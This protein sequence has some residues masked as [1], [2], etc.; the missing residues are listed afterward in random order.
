LD[1]VTKGDDG[2]QN[3]QLRGMIRPITDYLVVNEIYSLE[4]FHIL[5][6]AVGKAIRSLEGVILKDINEWTFWE[7]A[8]SFEGQPSVVIISKSWQFINRWV[9][10]S[11][12]GEHYNPEQ[13]VRKGIQTDTMDQS[14]AHRIMYSAFLSTVLKM[15]ASR[16]RPNWVLKESL[17]M[18]RNKYLAK[19]P[20]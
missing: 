6:V 15:V 9:D 8:E 14:E 16:G 17:A 7:S 4:Y 2:A 19:E 3:I 1:S 11:R 10:E 12:L 13:F 20:E 5:M 18:W